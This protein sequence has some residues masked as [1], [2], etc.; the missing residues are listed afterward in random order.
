M[1][2]KVTLN[3][4]VKLYTVIF[5]YCTNDTVY[6]TLESKS[7][8]TLVDVDYETLGKLCQYISNVCKDASGRVVLSERVQIVDIPN[9]KNTGGKL[10]KGFNDLDTYCRKYDKEEYLAFYN[11]ADNEL[12]ATSITY[13]SS[14]CIRVKC[15]HCGYEHEIT[16]SA[17]IHQKLPCIACQSKNHSRCMSGVND[18]YTYCINNNLEYLLDEYRGCWD[19]HDISAHSKVKVEWECQ[20]GHKW[21]TDFSHRLLGRNCPQCT[22]AQTSKTERAI[23]NWLKENGVNIREREKIQGQEFDIHILDYNILIEFNCDATHGTEEIKKKDKLKYKIAEDA[24]CK[25]I[26][27]FQ[28]CYKDTICE[29]YDIVFNVN[30]SSYM[31][32]VQNQ[33]SSMLSQYGLNIGNKISKQA[34]ADAHKNKVPYERSAKVVYP[35]IEAIWAESNE[36]SSDEYYAK[37]RTYVNLICTKYNL[38]YSVRLDSLSNKWDKTQ[39]CHT[40]QVKR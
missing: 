26:V 35:G 25:F 16:L 7:N 18:F 6:Y 32:D 23:G 9:I 21:I 38:E 31:Q 24:G 29:G 11:N 28:Q 8:R 37:S 33:L 19:L 39:G 12:P 14:Q 20:Y 17:F 5:C 13:S 22:G 4:Q 2:I 10:I 3:K 36:H 15:I 1:E 40:V 30:K 27:V 34:I